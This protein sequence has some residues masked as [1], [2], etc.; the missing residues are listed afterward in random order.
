MERVSRGGV[1]LELYRGQVRGD[2]QH[3]KRD[4][5]LFGL[6]KLA[7]ER[8]QQMIGRRLCWKKC[9]GSGQALVKARGGC[10]GEPFEM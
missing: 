1:V 10:S 9:F 5:S 7:L 2:E 4:G 3:Q 6:L 8:H